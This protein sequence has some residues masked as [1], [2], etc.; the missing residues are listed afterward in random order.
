MDCYVT[1]HPKMSW[2]E[3]KTKYYL[4]EVLQFDLGSAPASLGIFPEVAWTRSQLGWQSESS[5]GLGIPKGF[6]QMVGSW[7][8]LATGSS[9]EGLWFPLTWASHW[10][11]RLPHGKRK[12]RVQEGG[13]RLL[14]GPKLRTSTVYAAFHWVPKNGHDWRTRRETRSHLVMESGRAALQKHLKEEIL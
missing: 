4:L 3:T 8:W 10:S 9:A 7:C 13:A 5:A 11:P 2:L 14:T 1:N 6:P 12:S